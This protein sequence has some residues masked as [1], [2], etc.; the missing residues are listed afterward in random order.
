MQKLTLELFTCPY[1]D[2][3]QRQ[4]QIKAAI[5]ATVG[6]FRRN[7]LYPAL[8]D[9]IELYRTLTHLVQ[10]HEQLH[11][12]DLHRFLPPAQTPPPEDTESAATTTIEQMF[13]LIRWALPLIEDAIEEGTALF[14]FVEENIT[15][16]NVGLLPMYTSEG[17]VLIP[18]HRTYT[19]HV[20]RY[21]ASQLVEH[22]D[23]YRALRT[24]EVLRL[25]CRGIWSAPETIKRQLIAQYPDLPN[26]ATFTCETELDFPYTETILPVAKRKLMQLLT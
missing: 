23:R 19:V 15:L 18:E 7:Q 21:T 14:D 9:A 24:S 12:N 1:D 20:L 4:Y 16:T 25:Q 13:E 8:R 6:Q 11:P 17:Y 26:P 5:A 22:G 3:E 2:L 10:Q